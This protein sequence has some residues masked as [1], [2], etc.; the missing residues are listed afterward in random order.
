MKKI[1]ISIS[2]LCLSLAAFAGV[3]PSD[4]ALKVAQIFMDS[5]SLT[6]VW[7]GNEADTKASQDP[8][9]HV[10]N[11]KEGG[12]VIISGDDC[13]IPILGYS[14]SGSFDKDDMPP[15]MEWWLGL[16]RDD[17]RKARLTKASGTEETRYKWSHPG[18]A[19]TKAGDNSK[20]LVTAE[21]DQDVPYNRLLSQYVKNNGTGVE[22]L[23]TGCVATAMAEVLRY[24]QWPVHGTGTLPGYT[25]KSFRYTVEGFS[26]EDHQYR[27]DKMPMTYDSSWTTE[28]KD[29]VAQLMLDCGVMVEMDYGINGS[30]A[31]PEDVVPALTE[32]MQYSKKAELKSRLYF[33]DDE[34]LQMIKYDIDNCG[35]ILYGG[36]TTT[37]EGHQFICDGYDIGE[38]RLHI[39]WGWSGRYHNT[40]FTM[41]L[42]VPNSYTFSERQTAIFGL[43]PDRDG[44]STYADA[45]IRLIVSSNENAFNGVSLNSGTFAAGSTFYLDAGTFINRSYSVNYT[46]AVKAVLVD[47]DGN[48]KED[49]SAPRQIS[50]V[51]KPDDTFCLQGN[52]ALPCTVNGPIALGDR[53]VFWYLLNDG[54]WKPVRTDSSDLAHT[55]SVAYADVCFI[56]TASSY[57]DGDNFPLVIIPGNKVIT[58]V[59][60]TYDGSTVNDDSVRLSSGTHTVSAELTFS[61]RTKETITQVLEVN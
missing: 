12:W 24:H 55:W 9:F 20:V 14:E 38:R 45:D 34:W 6:E 27:W 18:G 36:S 57:R 19:A 43:V 39:N 53:I 37:N 61:D 5:A 23:Q 60:W 11:V 58:D 17:I 40:W 30:S 44:S 56:K 8:V 32:H 31:I 42:S 26:I 47:K 22:G 33:T 4:R 25:T 2:L 48:R 3:V 51:M 28:Q 59:V 13:T 10:F 1:F 49:A 52:D 54:T 15:A 46:G 35:P 29:A 50:G 41:S 16:M 21:W 7:D